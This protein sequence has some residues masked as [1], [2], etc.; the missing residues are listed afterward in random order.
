MNYW[1]LDSWLVR[2]GREEEFIAACTDLMQWTMQEVPG[3][4]GSVPLYRDFQQSNRFFCPMAWESVE[5]IAAWRANQG[6]HSRIEQL[7]AELENRTLVQV[8]RLFPSAA[9]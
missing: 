5:A 2:P 4:V 1:I 8:T 7:C 3:K 6:Y 9:L